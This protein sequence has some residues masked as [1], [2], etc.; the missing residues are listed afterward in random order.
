MSRATRLIKLLDKVLARHD[1]F[2]DDPGAFVEPVLDELKQQLEAIKAKLAKG[3]GGVR[4]GAAAQ[5]VDVTFRFLPD[6]TPPP[7]SPV[8]RAFVPGSFN[9]WGPNSSGRISSTAPSRMD[10]DEGLEEYRY[11]TSLTPGGGP[12]E[13][14][15]PYKIHYHSDGSGSQYTW[16]TDPLGT[17]AGVQHHERLLLLAFQLEVIRGQWRIKLLQT[18]EHIGSAVP[19][20]GVDPSRGGRLFRV[21]APRLLPDL[22][23][24]F[25]NELIGMGR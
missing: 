4:T 17:A 20:N 13:G 6:L 10:Y 7:I 25:L 23:H 11:T 18:P 5:S 8:V 2:G 12:A 1:S 21:E 22:K 16:L 19:R 3:T 14:G 9:D 15:Y 24:H